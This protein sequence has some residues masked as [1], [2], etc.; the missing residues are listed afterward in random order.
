MLK[1]SKIDL[2]QLAKE[3]RGLDRRQE[4]YRVLKEE[5]TKQGYWK[6]RARGNPAKGYQAMKSREG[7]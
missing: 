2:E 6:Q 7:G 3:I 4:L 5:L 1:M